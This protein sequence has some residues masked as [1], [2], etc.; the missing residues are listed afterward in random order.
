MVQ[1]CECPN[2]QQN[3][4]VKGCPLV[5]K[6][7]KKQF[8]VQTYDSEGNRNK[9]DVADLVGG[10][11][12]DAYILARITDTDPSKRWYPTP[13][14]YENVTPGRTE[15][16]TEEFNSGRIAKLDDGVRNFEGFII[17]QDSTLASKLASFGCNDISAFEVDTT[18]ALRGVSN[19]DRTILYPMELNSGSLVV[20]PVEEVEG[21]STSKIQVNFQYS[22]LVDES[23]LMII[24][25]S[26]IEVDLL[27]VNGLLD[28]TTNV[29][30]SPAIT[31]ATASANVTFN[32]FGSFGSTSYLQGLDVV[33]DWELKDGV[34]PVAI[35][36]ITDL[37]NDGSQLD[38]VFTSTPSTALTLNYVGLPANA[39]SQGF[40]VPTVTFTTPA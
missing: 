35:A 2:G 28:G 32:C 34:T 14:K 17:G 20:V 39:I 8:L 5:M 38:F 37:N 7:I 27:K 4:G 15:P 36:S 9:I 31:N 23:K 21:T 6:T 24:K 29:L 26:D 25:G 10:K 1:L 40:D 33:G 19:A 13:D 30:V 11:I 22:S 18:N 3:L 12:T 16:K